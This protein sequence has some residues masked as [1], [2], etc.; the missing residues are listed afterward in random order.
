MNEM[1]LKDN[2]DLKELEKY[3]FECSDSASIFWNNQDCSKYIR[4]W[5]HTRKIYCND[6]NNKILKMLQKDGLIE[7]RENKEVSE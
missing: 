2:V 1:K 7:K 5:F 6:Q 3:P 4:I